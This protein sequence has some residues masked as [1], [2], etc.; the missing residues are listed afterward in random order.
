MFAHKEFI[1]NCCDIKQLKNMAKQDILGI[2]IS[3]ISPISLINPIL[4][5]I[6]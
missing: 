5:I 3:L 4:D 6:V 1:H 2:I